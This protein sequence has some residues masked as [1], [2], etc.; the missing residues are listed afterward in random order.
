MKL[1]YCLLRTCFNKYTL[2]I[3]LS[4]NTVGDQIARKVSTSK[5]SS[6]GIIANIYP[7][8]KSSVLTF[9]LHITVY[10]TKRMILT[11]IFTWHHIHSNRANPGI[12]EFLSYLLSVDWRIK[13]ENEYIS[14]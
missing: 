2:Y 7:L 13:I 3:S 8:K 9:S 6:S 1:S 12:S 10:L 14:Y 4:A 11:K 5:Q